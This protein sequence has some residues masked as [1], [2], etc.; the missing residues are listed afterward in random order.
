MSAVTSLLSRFIATQQS[1]LE[2]KLVH[3]TRSAEKRAGTAVQQVSQKAFDYRKQRDQLKTLLA[4]YK[5]QNEKQER[6][7]AR[8]KELVEDYERSAR[9][10]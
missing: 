7:I 10:V 1:L 4:Q 5:E 9:R 6:E 2:A 3:D 8:Y